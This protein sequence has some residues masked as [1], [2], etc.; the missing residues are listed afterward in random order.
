MLDDPLRAWNIDETIEGRWTVFST[1]RGGWGDVYF[2]HDAQW[3]VDLAVKTAPPR[4]DPRHRDVTEALFLAETRTWLDLG[5][6]PQIVTGFYTK[7]VG[8]G[9]RFFM[10]YVLGRTLEEDMRQSRE[11]EA[12]LDAALQIAIGMEYVHSKGIA[13]GDLHPRNCLV[14]PDEAIRIT[15]FGLSKVVA[16]TGEDGAPGPGRQGQEE[17]AADV[18]DFGH[19]LCRLLSRK[20]PSDRSAPQAPR[21]L[22][23]LRPATPPD[24]EDLALRCLATA[25][26]ER[27]SFWGIR[28][29]LLRVYRDVTGRHYKARPQAGLAS[30]EA[31]ENNRAASYLEMD[32]AE[33]ARAILD[34]WL[35]KDPLALYPWVNRK[36]LELGE[37]VEPAK[38]AE[39]FTTQILPRHR[40]AIHGDP[41]LTSFQA[42]LAPHLLYH[43]QRVDS[44]CFSPD[45]RLLATGCRDGAVRVWRVETG[46]EVRRIKAVDADEDLAIAWSPGGDWI[47]AAAKDGEIS[48]YRAMTGDR[49]NDDAR[50]VVKTYAEAVRGIVAG[51][52]VNCVAASGTGDVLLGCGKLEKR[53][54]LFERGVGCGTWL[55]QAE[56]DRRLEGH[57]APVRIVAFFAGDAEIAAADATRLCVWNART[58][59]LLRRIEVKGIILAV[60]RDGSLLASSEVAVDKGARV[61]LRRVADGKEVGAFD[62]TWA[63]MDEVPL[64][65]AFAADSGLLAWGTLDGKIGIADVQSGQRRVI[66][67]FNTPVTSIDANP[68]GTLI[69]SASMQGMVFMWRTGRAPALPR[70]GPI[71]CR[72]LAAPRRVEI[73]DRRAVVLRRL[74]A[75][76]I[77]AIPV[78]EA[79][80]R[81][82]AGD[83]GDRELL[84]AVQR[85]GAAYGVRGAVRSATR[86]WA[87][88]SVSRSLAFSSDGERVLIAE[89]EDTLALCEVLTGA[90]L[91]RIKVKGVEDAVLCM[92]RDE[93]RAVVSVPGEDRMRVFDITRAAP[94]FDVPRPRGAASA[95]R[96]APESAL[97]RGPELLLVSERDER[98]GQVR[99]ASDGQLLHRLPGLLPLGVSPDRQLLFVRRADENTVRVLRRSDGGT[100]GDGSGDSNLVAVREFVHCAVDHLSA[101]ARFLFAAIG[102]RA[103]V[104]ST[105]AGE[106]V[107]A[108]PGQLVH[109]ATR[110]GRV[111]LVSQAIEGDQFIPCV[112]DRAHPEPFA[113]STRQVPVA[114]SPCGR[115]VFAFGLAGFGPW[116][117]DWAWSFFEDYLP[118]AERALGGEGSGAQAEGL[119]EIDRLLDVWQN[120][121]RAAARPGLPAFALSQL[122][123]FRAELLARLA[124]LARPAYPTGAD[125]LADP[126]YR[127]GLV[128]PNLAMSLERVLAPARRATAT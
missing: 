26:G 38:I 7:R 103:H 97:A 41:E 93:L 10:E 125:V 85:L 76:D 23:A 112:V 119:P 33:T 90:I 120:I 83:P 57:E 128:D 124:R 102:G 84:G 74:A 45:G 36:C 58:G 32:E 71:V 20:W 67:A 4:R 104:W 75:H 16:A 8:G 98:G 11:I 106:I 59:D 25:P 96:F 46:E 107:A 14:S 121:S 51:E 40:A 30:T 101:D 44:A 47:V 127:V 37:G 62:G 99:R 65:A 110:D 56:G 15:D 54:K 123:A 117:L 108:S 89:S 126:I 9:L 1:A 34:A 48:R 79:L 77:G 19:I 43:P 52:E 42:R 61:S 66:K 73:D 22:R 39:A 109:G 53:F 92:S 12:A 24:V 6:H 82:A 13:H 21:P 94:L 29:R 72:D 28:E 105:S 17:I 3:G 49:D 113:I 114:I 100:L 115:F 50:Y 91:Q 31:S 27:P 111:L 87:Q 86:L 69:A 116:R 60:T 122:A 55:L 2:V 81:E 78:A 118:L 88:P 64:T 63:N 5:A 68:E 35:D 70:F 18:L 80:L 95:L